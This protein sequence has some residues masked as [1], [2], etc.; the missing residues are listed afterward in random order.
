MTHSGAGADF[1]A[2]SYT[3]CQSDEFTCAARRTAGAAR[4]TL[5]PVCVGRAPGMAAFPGMLALVNDEK[6]RIGRGGPSSTTAVA[7]ALGRSGSETRAGG[8]GRRSH[9]PGPPPQGSP[10]RDRLPWPRLRAPLSCGMQ[11]D[12]TAVR[13]CNPRQSRASPLRFR[14][15]VSAP[16]AA[17]I[18]VSDRHS[19]QAAPGRTSWPG[20]SGGSSC[21]WAG[22]PRSQGMPSCHP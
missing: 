3:T 12:L 17:P 13:R 20:I 15:L 19:T 14:K 18:D 11:L 1:A 6:L 7:G 22:R 8:P 9:G 10:V 16:V 5:P 21:R 4:G 2:H